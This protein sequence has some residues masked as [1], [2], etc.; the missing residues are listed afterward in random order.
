[1]RRITALT[2]RDIRSYEAYDVSLSG[3]S[4]VITG[5]NGAGKTNLLETLTLFGAGRG[6]RGAKLSD[7]VRQGTQGEAGAAVTLT[8]PVDDDKVRLVVTIPP[9]QHDRRELRIDGAPTRSAQALSDHLRFLWLTPAMDR[10]F[11]DAPSE[12]R[13]FL[14]RITAAGDPQHAVQAARYEK[15]MRQRMVL[16]EQAGDPRLTAGFEAEMASAAIR[17]TVARREAATSLAQGYAELRE[18]AF[19]RASLAIEGD[20]ELLLGQHGAE[21]AEGLFRDRLARN[22]QIDQRARRTVAGPH[23]SDLLVTHVDKEMPAKLCSTGEQKA[24]LIGLIL[25]RAS[26][27]AAR[28]EGALVLLLDEIVAHLDEIRRKALAAILEQLGLQAF[29]TGTD[30]EPFAPFL[31][32]M[33][34][35]QPHLRE[36]P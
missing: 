9:P 8:E 11:I 29:L 10:L 35:L 23:R 3:R 36:N 12:R 26:A 13:R 28:G 27:A 20:V 15:A 24:L 21:A 22:R 30:A 19:P 6:L 16:L 2:L 32:A 33:D 34:H 14:D 4:V 31:E 7:I 1:M 25:A 17:M 5:P 18:E